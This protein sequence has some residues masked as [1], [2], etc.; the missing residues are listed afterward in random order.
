[1]KRSMVLLGA[2]VFAST[3][4]ACG[5]GDEPTATSAPEDTPTPAGVEVFVQLTEWAV[6]PT[7]SSAGAGD[8]MF[9][10]TNAGQIPHEL[11]ILKTDL[12]VD[13]LPLDNG[14][15]SETG[16]GTIIGEIEP[17]ELGAGQTAHA[18][19]NLASGSYALICNLPGH[20]AAGMYAGFT[21]N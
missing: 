13:Q 8:V 19:W 10:A 2:V 6:E 3:L 14:A 17:D 18:E 20:Y 21:V 11:V 7:V 4:A 12:P 16:A 15:V 5:G 9:T 1:M